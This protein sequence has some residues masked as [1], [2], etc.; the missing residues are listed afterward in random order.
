MKILYVKNNSERAKE[1]QLKTIIYEENGKKYVKKESLTAEATPHLKRMKESYE[2]LSKSTLNPNIEFAKIIDEDENSLTFEFIEGISFEKK[3]EQALLAGKSSVEKLLQEY[4]ELLKTGFK[5]TEFKS[6]TMATD[7]FK[8]IFGD[9]DYSCFNGDL[10]FEGISSI[11]LIFSN[12]IYKDDKIYFIDYE[13]AYSL[14]IPVDYIIHRTF[15]MLSTHHRNFKNDFAN[16]IFFYHKMERHFVDN[17]AMRDGFYFQK[18]S[19]IKDNSLIEHLALQVEG[20]EEHIQELSTKIHAIG[21]DLAHARNIVEHRD[22]Q[23][24]EWMAIVETLYIKNRVKQFAKRVIGKFMPSKKVNTNMEKSLT[25]NKLYGYKTPEL[26]ALLEDEL[27]NFKQKPLISIVMPVYDVDPKWLSLAI[28]SIE[29]QWY[30]N[31][32]LCIADDKSPSES[33]VEYLKS[34]TNPKIKVTFLEKNLNISGATNAAL[35]LASGDYIALMDNDDEITPNALYEMVK[36][37]N[38]HNAEFIYSDEDFISTEG[39]HTNPHFKPDFSP[40]LLLSHNYITHFT[41]FKKELLDRAGYFNPEFDGSQDYDLFLRLTE[42]TSKI[43]HIQKVLYHWRMLETS[44]SANSEAKPEAIERGRVV[45]EEALKRRGIKATVEHGNMHHYF[46]VKYNIE[47]NP[48]VSIV[49]PF[50]DKPELLDMSI[51]SILEKSTYKNYEII[52]ISNNS[53]EPET[54]KMMAELEKKDT[55]VSFHEYNVEFNYAD[56]NNYAI[57]TYAKGEHVLLLNNDIEIISPEWIESMLELSQREDVGCVGAKLYYPD[58]TIQHAGIIIGLGGYAGHSHKLS[59]RDS[60]GYFNRLSVVQNLSA[61]T[62]ACLMIKKSIYEEVNGM[63]EVR[64]KVAYNDVD[65]CLRVLEKGYLNIFTPFAQMYHHESISGGYETTPEKIARFQKEKDALSKRHN[66]ILTKGDP[67]YNPNLT[68]DK[69][70]FS[71]AEKHISIKG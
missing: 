29:A 24:E 30:E 23:I 28:N 25:S 54:F 1:F 18:K 43:Y 6:E 19:Y 17:Y 35:E 7:E 38:E 62:A 47:G 71:I 49:I 14:N 56:I 59:Q 46:R 3:F 13:W 9:L 57:K 2:K 53:E 4:V 61:V 20:K 42:K 22:G 48:L 41:C 66:A 55:R 36:A 50:K 8:T 12:I 45:V 15:E 64:F 65:F 11:D 40:D 44:T 26:T 70:N 63:D 21:E 68:H 67:Y 52:G 33:T 10:C 32:E 39:K 16:D 51:N 69:E 27:S 34:L 60:A 31:W 5:M 58:D 37:I